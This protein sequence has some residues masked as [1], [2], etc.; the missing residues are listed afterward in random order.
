MIKY[1]TQ[2]IIKRLPPLYDTE[3]TPLA[4]KVAQVKFF[5]LQGRG[6]WFG[7]EFDHE[8]RNFFGYVVSPLGPD[9]DE[10]GY[11]N[12]DE[13]MAVRFGPIPGIERDLYFKPKKMGE[14]IKEYSNR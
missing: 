4:E 9:C 13:L 14:I 1:L 2:G 10:L 11:F 5:S 3:N 12:L 8:T 7:I 6:T